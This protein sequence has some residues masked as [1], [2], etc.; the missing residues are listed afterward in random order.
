MRRT[1]FYDDTRCAMRGKFIWEMSGKSAITGLDQHDTLVDMH[2]HSTSSPL[3][4]YC[5]VSFMPAIAS[6]SGRLHSEFVRL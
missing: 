4:F 5:A 6:T 2:A 1:W 3:R